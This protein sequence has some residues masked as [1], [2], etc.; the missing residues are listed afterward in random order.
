[1]RGL[2][3]RGG[4]GRGED[5]VATLQE[6]GCGARRP[7]PG[8][9]PAEMRREM[10]GWGQEAAIRDFFFF[11]NHSFDFSCVRVK[12]R[13]EGMRGRNATSSAGHCRYVGRGSE[14]TCSTPRR[15]RGSVRKAFHDTGRWQR[16]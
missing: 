14:R 15:G 10:G 16:P 4:A 5:D 2:P 13:R 7:R 9:C 1:M 11:F 3:G 8:F 12:G 6:A